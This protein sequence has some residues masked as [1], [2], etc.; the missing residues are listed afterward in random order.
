MLFVF[1]V[2]LID[3]S[4][5]VIAIAKF[6]N[7][8]CARDSVHIRRTIIAMFDRS[9]TQFPRFSPSFF[10]FFFFFDLRLV[11]FEI[12]FKFQRK[13]RRRKAKEVRQT[14]TKRT[15]TVSHFLDLASVQR[16]RNHCYYFVIILV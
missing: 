4:N 3:F 11:N 1:L 13:F 14:V 5:S 8:R 15:A 2:S 10:F 7:E 12:R 6:R 16:M 9:C